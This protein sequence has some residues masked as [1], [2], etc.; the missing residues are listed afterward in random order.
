VDS[1]TLANEKNDEY[2]A[3]KAGI[4]VKL[5]KLKEELELSEHTR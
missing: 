2:D 3:Y 5:S 1:L 4:D